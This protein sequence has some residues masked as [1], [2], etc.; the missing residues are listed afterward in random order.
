MLYL[1]HGRAGAVGALS[2]LACGL[3]PLDPGAVDW[4]GAGAWGR[5]GVFCALWVWAA[6]IM[7][8]V[9]VWGSG[10]IEHRED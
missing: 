9:W 7:G 2:K 3:P 4:A 5:A 8:L 6:C 10:S 1:L